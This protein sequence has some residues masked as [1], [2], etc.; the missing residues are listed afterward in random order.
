[1]QTLSNCFFFFIKIISKLNF[2]HFW[3]IKWYH[4]IPQYKWIDRNGANTFIKVALQRSCNYD[5]YSSSYAD[6]TT[7]YFW[8]GG[9]TNLAYIN[10]HSRYNSYRIYSWN[11][12]YGLWISSNNSLFGTV[13][14]CID[15]ICIHYPL[16]LKNVLT[17]CNTIIEKYKKNQHT[18]WSIGISPLFC[19]SLMMSKR[20]RINQSHY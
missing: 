12:Q 15:E 2:V 14:K 7:I 17:F 9:C 1:M 18:L 8:W 3:N 4:V 13:H 6:N 16:L 11:G 10:A 20:P 5:L 19:S